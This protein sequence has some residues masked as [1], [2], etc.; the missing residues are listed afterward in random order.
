MSIPK[1]IFVV[2]CPRSGTTLLQSILATSPAI[3][4]FPESHF[5]VNLFRRRSDLQKK[6]NFASHYSRPGFESFMLEAG[7]ET[8][9]RTLPTHA[10]SL[11]QHT[12]TFIDTLDTIARQQQKSIW[13]EKTPDHVNFI[14]FIETHVHHAQFI[15][16]VRPGSDVVASLYDVTHKYPREWEGPWGIDRC[17]R[18]WTTCV[19]N[20]YKHQ[21]KPNHLIVRYEHLVHELAGVKRRLGEFLRVNLDATSLDHRQGEFDKIALQR[22]PWKMN[23]SQE[24]Y[25]TKADKFSSLFTQQ[26]QDYVLDAISQ[27]GLTDIESFKNSKQGERHC[28]VVAS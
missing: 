14:D 15:H 12:R 25:Q 7:Y 10:V 13:I 16:I 4:S 24:I 22:E 5:F 6:L 26:Q 18:K 11:Q 1:R 19:T 27:A 28:S 2:G 8:I 17:L 23:S 9:R 3:I 20:T 21:A